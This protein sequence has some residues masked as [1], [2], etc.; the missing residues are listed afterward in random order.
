[1]ASLSDQDF[2]KFSQLIF[3]YAGIHMHEGKK[4]LVEGRLRKRL[5]ALSLNSYNE[6]YKIVKADSV[7]LF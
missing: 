4:A 7:P 3:K 1:M 2:K 5:V 6:Y